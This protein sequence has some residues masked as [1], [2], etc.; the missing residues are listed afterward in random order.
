MDNKGDIVMALIDLEATCDIS[1]FPKDETEIIEIGAVAGTFVAENGGFALSGEEFR[2]Y[3]R[4]EWHPTLTP[5]CTELTGIEQR[6]VDTAPLLAQ[7]LDALAK[8]LTTCGT[9]VWGSWGDYDRRQFDRETASKQLDNPMPAYPHIN[10]KPLFRMSDEED[11]GSKRKKRRGGGLARAVRRAG[12]EFEGRHHSG[13]DDARNIGRLLETVKAF[14][15]GTRR[16]AVEA[17]R[18]GIR[19]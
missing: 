8:W 3:L 19:S 4:P 14:R 9:Q 17:L 11:E 10:V 16:A 1:D 2:T 7:G 13:L 12:L 18:A 15:T 6:T 5:F